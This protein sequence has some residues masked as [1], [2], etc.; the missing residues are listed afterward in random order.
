MRAMHLVATCLMA[1]FVSQM[2]NAYPDQAPIAQQQPAPAPAPGPGPVPGPVPP[3]VG[4]VPPIVPP[5]VPPIVPPILPP[6]L[7]PLGFPF[8]GPLGL[9]LP[10]L[11]LGLGLGRL[12]LLARLALIG[13]RSVDEVADESVKCFINTFTKT[14][15]CSDSIGQRVACGIESHFNSSIKLNLTDLAITEKFTPTRGEIFG[16]LSP[17]S[18]L[19]QMQHGQG[20]VGFLTPEVLSNGKFTFMDPVTLKPVFLSFYF[21]VTIDEPGFVVKD[22]TCYDGIVDMILPNL[23]DVRFNLI[24]A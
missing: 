4:P 14:I 23:K 3:P 12:G 18:A 6:L 10:L 2:T 15:D 7:G 24:V 22:K 19:Y 9:P 11:G 16:L 1:V 13:K 8:L 20:L 21:D 17:K 5:M